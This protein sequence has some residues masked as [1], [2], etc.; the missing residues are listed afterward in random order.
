MHPPEHVLAYAVP[1]GAWGHLDCLPP[2]IYPGILRQPL[3]RQAPSPGNGGIHTG[4]PAGPVPLR[5]HPQTSY[6]MVHAI[7][8]AP[9][10]AAEHP[11]GCSQKIAEYPT[12]RATT[13]RA[14]HAAPAS[15]TSSWTPKRT[16]SY[17]ISAA[18]TT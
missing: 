8:P 3:R 2:P 14:T 6:E 1:L 4:L 10:P 15:T 7:T 16:A 13:S 9:G 12:N 5:R 11:A 18:T 17:A